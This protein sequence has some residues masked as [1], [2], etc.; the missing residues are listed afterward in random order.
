MKISCMKQT[1]RSIDFDLIYI[2]QFKK[3]VK[4]IDMETT[5]EILRY[6]KHRE[7]WLKISELMLPY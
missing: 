3:E 6:W 1:Q 4:I 2:W 5:K 7:N